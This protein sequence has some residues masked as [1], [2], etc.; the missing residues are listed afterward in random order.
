MSSIRGEI[1]NRLT[2]C[3]VF[4]GLLGKYQIAE[5]GTHSHY[6][7]EVWFRLI[8]AWPKQPD[9][10][11]KLI[12]LCIKTFA[13]RHYYSV[14]PFSKKA[15]KYSLRSVIDWSESLLTQ[16]PENLDGSFINEE[17][18]LGIRKEISYALFP[19]LINQIDKSYLLSPLWS[20]LANHGEGYSRILILLC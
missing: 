20:F 19:K 2:S 17:I 3:W 16:L 18:S 5:F 10:P 6:L 8:C 15:Q 7:E 13:Q 11:G 4:I 9:A 1:Q 14:T 12:L